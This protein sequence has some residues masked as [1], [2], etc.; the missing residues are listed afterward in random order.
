MCSGGLEGHISPLCLE[1]EA[2][3]KLVATSVDVLAVKES[4]ECQLDACTDRQQD[5]PCTITFIVKECQKLISKSIKETLRFE[6][7]SV[8]L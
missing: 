3:T 2:E 5:K 4:R 7:T 6:Y 8:F 1:L